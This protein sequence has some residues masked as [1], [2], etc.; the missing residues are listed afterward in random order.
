MHT[1]KTWEFDQGT[2]AKTADGQTWDTLIVGEVTC[3]GTHMFHD[4]LLKSVRE[5]A[6]AYVA[7]CPGSVVG[8]VMRAE[9]FHRANMA[10]GKDVE[11]VTWTVVIPIRRRPA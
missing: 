4:V 11:V 10:Y 5:A 2:P 9:K 6:S 8:E 7:D 3:D 1:I